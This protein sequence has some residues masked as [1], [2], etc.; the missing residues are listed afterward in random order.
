MLN[1]KNFKLKYIKYKLKYNNLKTL[2]GGSRQINVYNV[3]DMSN[4]F[5]T[6]DLD[7]QDDIDIVK[8]QILQQINNP[9]LNQSNISLRAHTSTY[10]KPIELNAI[11]N[12][13]TSICFTLKNCVESSSLVPIIIKTGE[14]SDSWYNSPYKIVGSIIPRP[15]IELLTPRIMQAVKELENSNKPFIIWNNQDKNQDLNKLINIAKPDKNN[16]TESEK[17]DEI[18]SLLD[19]PPPP[20]PRLERT[21]MRA[22][23]ERSELIENIANSEPYKIYDVRIDTNG[24]DYKFWLKNKNNYLLEVIVTLEGK[25]LSI[26]NKGLINQFI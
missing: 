2:L 5:M 15:Q 3:S 19:L 20:A 7:L 14:S 24:R 9:Q 12:D 17:S 10:C 23:N 25:V 18:P 13:I 21:S 1:Q 11:G 6:I 8:N 22:Q 16:I 26:M 4:V